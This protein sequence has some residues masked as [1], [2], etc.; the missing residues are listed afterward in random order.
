MMPKAYRI[1]F[2]HLVFYISTFV[3]ATQLWSIWG[4]SKHSYLPFPH[5]RNLQ[6]D[7]DFNADVH[8]NVHTLSHEQCDSAFPKLYHSLD[9]SVSLR[10]GRKVHIQDIQ[11]DQ[12]RCMLRVMIYEGEVRSHMSGQRLDHN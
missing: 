5:H 2:S 9:Q 6:R 7:W 12:G 4:Q 8:A 1:S 10:Q 11:I 3:I